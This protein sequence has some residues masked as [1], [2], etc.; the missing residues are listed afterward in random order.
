MNN[1]II[2]AEISERNGWANIKTN[3]GKEISIMLSKPRTSLLIFLT[4]A[5][6]KVLA[7][8]LT[9]CLWTYEKQYSY[10]RCMV[11]DST[12]IMSISESLHAIKSNTS[13]VAKIPSSPK[14]LVIICADV[15][16]VA[17]VSI[18]LP[19]YHACAIGTTAVNT[20]T[21]KSASKV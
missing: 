6:V 11:V 10:K 14:R 7:K 18:I 2:V 3:E 1:V 9:A 4:N 5:P 15:S 20:R 13:H 19:K 12:R 21:N 16:S 17:I 8:N